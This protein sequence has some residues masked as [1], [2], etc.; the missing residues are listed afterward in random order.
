MKKRRIILDIRD[1]ITDAQALE[2]VS[3]IV[4][5]GKES[6]PEHK[7]QYCYLS[8]FKSG[9]HVSVIKRGKSERFLI[10]KGDKL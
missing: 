2:C 8:I 5:C 10:Y 1:D 3:A 9:I 4:A 7:R 6:G